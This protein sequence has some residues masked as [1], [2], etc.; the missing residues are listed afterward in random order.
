MTQLESQY[1]FDH[2][3][4]GYVVV[5]SDRLDQW[6]RFAKDGLGLH[7]DQPRGDLLAFRIDDHQRRILVRKGRAEDVMALGWQFDGE[8]T[9]NA[10]VDRLKKRSI[11]VLQGTAGEATDRGVKYFWRATGP[12]GVC[13]EL[14]TTPILAPGHLDMRCSGFVTGR[15]GLGHVAITTREPEAMRAFWQEIFE[16]RLSDEIEDRIDGV[17]LDFAFLRLNERHHSVA[18]ASTRGVRLDPLRTRIHHLNLQA[19]SLEDVTQGYLRCKRLGFAMANSIGQHPNDKELSYYVASPSGFEIEIG[20]NPIS[21]REDGWQAQRYHGV[22][23]WGHRPE[24]LTPRNRL[25]R[26]A[27]GLS[28]LFRKEYTVKG[29]QP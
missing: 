17:Q 5:E 9:L 1:I 24:N 2:V 15:A 4:L 14:Y 20:W 6:R 29:P 8:A 25:G 28:S 22:S 12:K 16:A 27:Q 7:V 23:L 21:V 10:V 26:F 11:Q 13:L 18:I 19:A 3:R